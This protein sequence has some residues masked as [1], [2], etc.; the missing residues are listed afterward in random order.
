MCVSFCFYIFMLQNY[1]FSRF[2]LSIAL[3][4]N[5]FSFFCLTIGS[6]VH[7][8]DIDMKTTENNNN[9]KSDI[10][11]EEIR[12]SG[13]DYFL[14][15]ENAPNSRRF[16]AGIG[17]ETNEINK[18]GCTF[19]IYNNNADKNSISQ[20]RIST[21]K[22]RWL[23]HKC[24]KYQDNVQKAALDHIQQMKHKETPELDMQIL[25]YSNPTQQLNDDERK[26]IIE[27][28][29]CK[30]VDIRYLKPKEEQLLRI[31][32]MDKWLFF[33][34]SPDQEDQVNDGI[35]YKAKNEN[36]PLL[37]HFG[38][39]FEHDFKQAKK[40][41]LKDEKITFEE[42]S[43]KTRIRSFWNSHNVFT[44]I[45]AWIFGFLGICVGI[46]GIYLAWRWKK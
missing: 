26:N 45:T 4:S 35:L 10:E 16:V 42:D 9:Q 5:I 3:H 30:G 29:Q 28:L 20:I 43:L 41:I 18:V 38:K 14:K 13:F 44:G 36:S 37:K 19:F 21:N 31:S 11:L 39:R 8:K 22:L 40:I 25:L 27:L 34:T 6:K 7:I 46:V 2:F 23:T 15:I 12:T 24:D 32:M 17:N 33:S 1:I